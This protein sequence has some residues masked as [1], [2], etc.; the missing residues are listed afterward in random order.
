MTEAKTCGDHLIQLL[1]R[2]PELKPK[3]RLIGEDENGVI[4]SIAF[5]DIPED[6]PEMQKDVDLFIAAWTWIKDE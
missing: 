1:D 4:A 2:Y 5:Q 3:F 6:R